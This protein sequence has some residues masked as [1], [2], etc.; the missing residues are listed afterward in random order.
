MSK[1]KLDHKVEN[2]IE[3]FYA[4]EGTK[5]LVEKSA[6][7]LVFPAVYKAGLAMFGGA[8]GEGALI[9]KDKTEA[10]YNLAAASFGFQ[11]GVQAYS[12]VMVF[13]T[14]E[15]LE[16]F[17]N[18]DGWQ[19]GVNAS[20]AVLDLGA[21]AVVNTDSV[22]DSVVAFAFDQEGLM[23]SLSLEGTKISREL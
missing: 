16:D 6:G 2:T 10:Y 21:G 14:E 19:V 18:S 7:V 23:Y 5:K 8:Y 15:A 12:L 3:K 9:V 22:K 1:K 17:R 11:L 4:S 13:L 20:V